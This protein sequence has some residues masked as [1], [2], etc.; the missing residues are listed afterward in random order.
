MS[1]SVFRGLLVAEAVFF[2]VG[3]AF[4][5]LGDPFLPEHLRSIEHQGMASGVPALD[6]LVDLLIIP[7]LILYVV[8]LLLLW[9]FR[10]IGRLLY[11]ASFLLGVLLVAPSAYIISSGLLLSFDICAGLV[12][13]AILVASFLPPLSVRF[14]DRP[15]A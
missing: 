9:R 11:A 8:A 6:R 3:I 7:D 1:T 13:G 5:F 15:T 12:S 2:V 4:G 14:K 10:K